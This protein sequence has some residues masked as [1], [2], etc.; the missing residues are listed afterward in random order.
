MAFD[1]RKS[2]YLAAVRVMRHFVKYKLTIANYVPIRGIEMA[3]SAAGE[4]ASSSVLNGDDEWK[5]IDRPRAETIAGQ[6]K[7]FGAPASQAGR[8]RCYPL[9]FPVS[10]RK[11]DF[12]SSIAV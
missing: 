8:R 3:I 7:M 2:L 4:F 5:S 11:R 12:S 9:S 10:T 1:A 6:N